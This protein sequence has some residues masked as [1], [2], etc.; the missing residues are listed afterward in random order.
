MHLKDN[1]HDLG[2]G[3][4][5]FPWVV[6]ALDAIGFAEWAQLETSHPTRSVQAG[7]AKNLSFVRNLMASRAANAG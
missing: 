7:M 2:Q 3:S 5:D 1:P 4:I 6:A